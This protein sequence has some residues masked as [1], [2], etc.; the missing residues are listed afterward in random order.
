MIEIFQT[1]VVVSLIAS[2]IYEFAM[3]YYFHKNRGF[4]WEGITCFCMA[5]N[6]NLAYNLADFSSYTASPVTVLSYNIYLASYVLVV[7]GLNNH[8][9]YVL[10]STK[11]PGTF[12]HVYNIISLIVLAIVL[13]IPENHIQVAYYIVIFLQL[14]LCFINFLRSCKLAKENRATLYINAVGEG[15]LLVRAALSLIDSMGFEAVAFVKLF[16]AEAYVVL[17]ILMFSAIYR[18]SIKSTK[19]LSNSLQET[20]TTINHSSNAL[21]CTQMK[22]D[23]LYTSLSLISKKCDEDPWVAEDLTISLSKY[24]RHTLNFQQLKGIVP[25]S[26]EIELTKAY[27]AIERERHPNI[28]FDYNFPNPIPDF[29]IPPLSIQP[30]VE[31]A[32]EHAFL[33][34]S[35]DPHISITISDFKE[36]YH[37][38]VSDNGVG[39]DEDYANGLTDSLHDSARIGVYS[40]HTRL[41]GLFGKG[42]VIQSAPGVGSSISFVVPPNALDYVKEAAN[43]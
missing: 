2:A 17:M 1:L 22:S 37:I 14:I 33:P 40:I 8:S 5:L 23:F 6:I 24:L 4:F 19:A 26:N 11:H 43:E 41:Q 42:L 20:I 34:D 15:L 38:D 39:M 27:I 29:H 25:L 32:I 12:E 18:T 28:T 9:G 13:A 21:L 35:K 36:Y 3:G 7:I 30:L 10:T 16:S 31:N